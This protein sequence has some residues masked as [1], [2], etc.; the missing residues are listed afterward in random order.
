MAKITWRVTKTYG[1][2]VLGRVAENTTKHPI[3]VSVDCASRRTQSMLRL[4]SPGLDR[5]LPSPESGL[6]W[7]ICRVI[8]SVHGPGDGLVGGGHAGRADRSGRLCRFGAVEIE[9]LGHVHRVEGRDAGQRL[10]HALHARCR[11]A[12]AA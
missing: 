12:G 10:V 6:R 5:M 11:P 9:R 7:S 4:G 8:A 2:A 1:S 3:T